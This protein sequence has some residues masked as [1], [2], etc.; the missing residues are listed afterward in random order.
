MKKQ[1]FTLIELLVVISIIAI[2]ASM[3]MPSLSKAREKA[4]S[5]TCLNNLKQMGLYT[6]MY[7]GDND[8]L[9]PVGNATAAYYS[10]R[11]HAAIAQMMGLPSA[12]TDK[13]SYLVDTRMGIANCQFVCPSAAL[14]SQAYMYGANYNG[15][16]RHASVNQSAPFGYY[17]GGTSKVV[18]KI[19]K[20]DPTV[21]MYSDGGTAPDEGR[22]VMTNPTAGALVRDISG[23]GI[24]DSDNNHIYS[25]WAPTRHGNSANYVLVDGSATSKTFGEWQ[26]AMNNGGFIYIP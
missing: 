6:T 10:M 16:M 20:L 11:W 22:N 15:S 17:D 26:H 2:L 9:L 24:L 8:D 3:L 21:C 1:H 12:N 5:I 14:P 18:K 19:I 13:T 23:D 25:R 4:R 7:A